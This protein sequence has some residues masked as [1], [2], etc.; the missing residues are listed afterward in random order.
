MKL[1]TQNKLIICKN[2][3]LK[4]Y[5]YNFISIIM[6]AKLFCSGGYLNILNG[7]ISLCHFRVIHFL[8]WFFVS[9]QLFRPNPRQSSYRSQAKHA[10]DEENVETKQK[11]IFQ[12]SFQTKGHAIIV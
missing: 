6:L 3:C 5:D 2:I 10:Y 9:Q 8:L 4:C 12:F 1:T 7:K 11:N